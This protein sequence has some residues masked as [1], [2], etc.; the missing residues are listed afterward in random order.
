MWQHVQL[1][2]QI[3]PLRHTNMFLGREETNEKENNL[4]ADS[5]RDLYLVSDTLKPP[6]VPRLTPK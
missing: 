5:F 3:G 4:T 1:S 6:I 2:E